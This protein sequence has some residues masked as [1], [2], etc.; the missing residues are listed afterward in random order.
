MTAVLM[1][2]LQ[3]LP[4]AV[5]DP[6]AGATTVMIPQRRRAPCETSPAPDEVVVCGKAHDDRFRLKPIPRPAGMKAPVDGPGVDFDIGNVHGNLY[7]IQV[8]RP[9]GLP[10]KR[11][12]VTLTMPF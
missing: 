4:V 11:I 12:M 8:G 7:A 2:V 10:D 9:D 5:S 6:P 3:A 1:L